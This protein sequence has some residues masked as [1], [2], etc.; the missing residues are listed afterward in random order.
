[1]ALFGR[2]E[3]LQTPL[4]VLSL[5]FMPGHVVSAANLVMGTTTA[6]C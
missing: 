1:M 5:A 4:L 3:R 2:N 6:M